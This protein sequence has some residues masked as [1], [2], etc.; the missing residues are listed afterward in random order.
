MSASQKPLTLMGPSNE[1]E[2]HYVTIYADSQETSNSSTDLNRQGTTFIHSSDFTGPNRSGTQDTQ[3]T[4]N[5]NASSGFD[6]S[7]PWTMKAVL[8]LGKDFTEAV[9]SQ[10][11]V[12][13]TLQMAVE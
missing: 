1:Y 6:E 13:N 10:C 11:A 9:N 12:A 3:D 2:G 7:D 4:S 8:T 5:T